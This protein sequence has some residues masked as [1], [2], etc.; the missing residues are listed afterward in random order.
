LVPQNPAEESG[1]VREIIAT[2]KAPAAIGP[3]SQGVRAGD[4]IFLAGQAGLEPQTGNLRTGIV[5]Q[6]EQTLDNLEAVL[7]QAGSSFADVVKTTIFVVD[8]GDFATVNSIYGKRFPGDKPARSTVQ[9]AALP[10]GALVEIEMVA[11]APR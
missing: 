10:K 5:E 4:F 8:L 9:V 7:Q 11:Y 2:S 6:T 3:Y 1:F